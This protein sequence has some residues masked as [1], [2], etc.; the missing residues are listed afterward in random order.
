MTPSLKKP[1][2]MP[3]LALAIALVLPGC[4][5]LTQENYDKLKIGMPYTEVVQLLGEPEQC[6]SLVG[7]KSCTWGKEPRTITVRFVAD[8]VILF[9]G[10]GL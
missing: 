5:R 10:K 9:E 8:N 1:Q 7:F 2:L 6:E 3:A 4:S